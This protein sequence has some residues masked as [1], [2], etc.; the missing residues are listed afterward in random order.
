MFNHMDYVAYAVLSLMIK[1]NTYLFCLFCLGCKIHFCLN[2]DLYSA[3]VNTFHVFG[4]F[5]IETEH[6]TRICIFE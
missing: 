3:W 5:C 6:C 2:T 4:S 1:V